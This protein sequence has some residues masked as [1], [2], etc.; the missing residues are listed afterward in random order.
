[1]IEKDKRVEQ[2]DLGIAPPNG[3]RDAKQ[4]AAWIVQRDQRRVFWLTVLTGLL[5]TLTGAFVIMMAYSYQYWITP[6]LRAYGQVQQDGPSI[7]PKPGGDA[8]VQQDGPTAATLMVA[9]GD[10]GARLVMVC[11]IGQMFAVVSTIALI[12]A[13]RRA[14][15]SQINA[16][17]AEISA[18]LKMLRGTTS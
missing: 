10:L 13:A 7:T 1:M 16:S 12:L 8:Q 2:V 14:T 4:L 17:L 15:Q 18:Q 11:V 6:K 3:A 5:W 9:V